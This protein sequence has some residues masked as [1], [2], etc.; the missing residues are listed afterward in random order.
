MKRLILIATTT[1]LF[2]ALTLWGQTGAPAKST[3]GH[4]VLTAA[5]SQHHRNKQHNRRHHTHHTGINARR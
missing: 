3:S 5:H 1:V 4:I 2:S